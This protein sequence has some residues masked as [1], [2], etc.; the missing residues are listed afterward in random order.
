[1]Y[2]PEYEDHEKA[3]EAL[4]LVKIRETLTEA[5]RKR[6]M[7]DVPIGVLLS[8]GLDSSFTS[9]IAARLLKEKG[10]ELRSFS[11]GLDAEA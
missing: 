4:D 8:G 10:K 6:L 2:R 9:S 7:S 3:T 5:T 11:I 1:Y